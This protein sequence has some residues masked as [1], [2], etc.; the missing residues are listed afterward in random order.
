M[1][2]PVYEV[3][4]IRVNTTKSTYTFTSVNTGVIVWRLNDI[5]LIDTNTYK[6]QASLSKRVVVNEHGCHTALNFGAKAKENKDKIPTLYWL[7]KRHKKSVKQDY[8]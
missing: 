8:C 6:L 7:P 1:P 5:G 3:P 4:T 2:L